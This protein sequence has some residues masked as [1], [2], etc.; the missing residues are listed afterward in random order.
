MFNIKVDITTMRV[1]DWVTCGN[2][3]E[4]YHKTALKRKKTPCCA[5]HWDDCPDAP[6]GTVGEYLEDV[7]EYIENNEPYGT[8][9]HFTK[10]IKERV[11]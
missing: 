7:H 9:E 3:S 1:L 8:E 2:C 11:L 6:I 4:L 10:I 5:C